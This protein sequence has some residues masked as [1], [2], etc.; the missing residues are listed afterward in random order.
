MGGHKHLL[1]IWQAET[2]KKVLTPM[3]CLQCKPCSMALSLPSHDMQSTCCTYYCVAGHTLNTFFSSTHREGLYGS[4]FICL[5]APINQ[6]K[7][8]DVQPDWDRSATWQL[9]TQA[10]PQFAALNGDINFIHL[11][12]VIARAFGFRSNIAHGTYLMSKAIAAIQQG[13]S[14][15]NWHADLT[16]QQHALSSLALAN[17]EEAVHIDFPSVMCGSCRYG[18]AVSSD[19]VSHIQATSDTS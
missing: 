17:C 12:P 4:C 18:G 16:A 5:Q 1:V 7:E 9:T 14:F 19:C 3:D 8:T 6:F 2:C 10:G 13:K 15:S 11:H